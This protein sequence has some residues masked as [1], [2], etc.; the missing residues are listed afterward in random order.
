MPENEYG[1][2]TLFAFRVKAIKSDLLTLLYFVTENEKNPA[3][4]VD[5]F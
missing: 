2:D 3:N 5:S 1:F 4:F